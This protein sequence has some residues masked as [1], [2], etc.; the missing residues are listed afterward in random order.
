M[1]SGE[2]V[3]YTKDNGSTW[4]QA[5]STTSSSFTLS[6]VTGI[7]G[8]MIGS[9]ITEQPGSSGYFV[10]GV[11]AYSNEV[12]RKQ[13]GVSAGLLDSVGAVSREVGEAMAH[14]VRSRLGTSLGSR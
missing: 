1:G 8:G 9:L 13:L 4:T 7:T 2:F 5:T 6:G 3:E 14:G 10:G 12:K 11:I